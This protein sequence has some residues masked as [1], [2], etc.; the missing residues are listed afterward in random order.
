MAEQICEI[1]KEQGDQARPTG[2][3]NASHAEALIQSDRGIIL[4][5]IAQKLSKQCAQNC[6]WS[7]ELY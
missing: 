6:A 2:N 1:K 3:G 7:N 5:Q 4:S